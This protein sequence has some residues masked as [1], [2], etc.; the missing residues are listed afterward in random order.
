MNK[1]AGLELLF[2]IFFGLLHRLIDISMNYEVPLPPLTT[3]EPGS[4]CLQF[5]I[6]EQPN[7][8]ADLKLRIH[9]SYLMEASGA[10]LTQHFGYYIQHRVYHL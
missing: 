10:E 7:S 4:S 3:P 6:Q 5:C 9:P 1:G 2:P 8:A